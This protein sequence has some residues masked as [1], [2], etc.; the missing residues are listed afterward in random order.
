[1]LIA[2]NCLEILIQANKVSPKIAGQLFLYKPAKDKVQLLNKNVGCRKGFKFR[3]LFMITIAFSIFARII[4]STQNNKDVNTNAT[5]EI[6]LCILML[7]LLLFVIER[8]RMWTYYPEDFV[9]FLN[10]AIKMERKKTAGIIS[11]TVL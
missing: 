3:W 9:D 11:K 4:I 7:A 5:V 10:G 6:N 1:M 8:Y 2:E